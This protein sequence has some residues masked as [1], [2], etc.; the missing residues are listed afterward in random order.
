MNM[1]W[2]YLGTK[3][4]GVQY[5]YIAVSSGCSIDGSSANYGVE[6]G[7]AVAVGVFVEVAVKVA[8]GDEVGV[9][10]DGVDERVG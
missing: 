8:V 10:E 6:V 3:A 1:H 2:K 7:V 5:D 4:F 9:A